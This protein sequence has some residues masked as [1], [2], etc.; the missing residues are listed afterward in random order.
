MQSKSIRFRAGIL[1][2]A[3]GLAT[4][5]ST[6]VYADEWV[7]YLEGTWVG[8]G[9]GRTGS[10]NNDQKIRCRFNGSV[11]SENRVTFSGRCASTKRRGSIS[12][13]L[14]AKSGSSYSGFAKSIYSK[15][16]LSY[17][18]QS[19]GNSIAITATQPI[20]RDDERFASRITIIQSGPSEMDFIEELRNLGTGE[21]FVSVRT[22]FQR[23]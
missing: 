15:K 17:V 23:K 19:S 5:A 20:E 1:G 11:E 9:T 14:I 6:A 10:D 16:R 22:R 12:M 4:T 7:N 18:G 13:I 2:F 8:S 3:L 21:Q